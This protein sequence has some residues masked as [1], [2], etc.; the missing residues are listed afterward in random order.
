M[1]SNARMHSAFSIRSTARF[2]GGLHA[3]IAFSSIKL[4]ESYYDFFLESVGVILSAMVGAG[5][6][7]DAIST[8]KYIY[9]LNPARGQPEA[10]INMYW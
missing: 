9:F 8:E 1:P 2:F 3:S 4:V 7:V 6:V 5:T 10:H